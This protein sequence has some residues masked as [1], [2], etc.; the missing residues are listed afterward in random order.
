MTGK[1]FV[2]VTGYTIAAFILTLAN[3][4]FWPFVIYWALFDRFLHVIDEG[5][6]ANLLAADIRKYLH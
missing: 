4:S 6:E 2:W 3:P 1:Q 5:Y